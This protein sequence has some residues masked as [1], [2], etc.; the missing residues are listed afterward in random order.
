MRGL[1][2]LF[3][4]LAALAASC[5]DRGKPEPAAFS[6]LPEAPSAGDAVTIRYRPD[7]SGSPLARAASIELRY[8]LVS[9]AGDVRSEE[10]PMTSTGGAWSASFVPSE[11]MPEGP[12][13]LV[14]AF[15]NAD[16]RDAYDNNR[17][18]P[19]VVM[20]RED[21]RVAEGANLQLSRI[22]GGELRLEG[23]VEMSVDRDLARDLVRQELAIWP[24][25]RRAAAASWSLALRELREDPVRLDS[26][27]TAIRAVVDDYFRVSSSWA[28]LPPDAVPMLEMYDR[29]GAEGRHD[30]LSAALLSRF[31]ADSATAEYGVQALVD[32]RDL[33]G[34][35]SRLRD[36]LDEHPES[37]ASKLGRGMLLSLYMYRLGTPERAAE[38]VRTDRPID[39]QYLVGYAEWLAAQ[40]GRLGEAE[41]VFRRCWEEDRAAEWTSSGSASRSEW[42][43]FQR[44][45]LSRTGLGLAGVLKESGRGEEAASLLAELALA[46]GPGAEADPEVLVALAGAEEDLG[47]PADAVRTFERLAERWMPTAEALAGWRRAYEAAGSGS[48]FDAYSEGYRERRMARL[49]ERLAD[50]ALDRPAPDISF[51]DPTGAKSSLSDYRGKVVLIDFWATWCGPCRR[52]LPQ[53]DEIYAKRGEIGDFEILPI[54]VWERNAGEERRTAVAASWKELGLSM[55]YFL[56][57][58]APAGTGSPATDLFHVSGIP[59]S[60]VIGRDGKI[61]FKTVGYEGDSAIEEMRA[62]IAIALGRPPAA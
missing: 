48:D 7:L 6:V 3:A 30:S 19:W 21:G 18:D 60:F 49:I 38:V 23:P 45:R 24:E 27:R 59:T 36:F 12:V 1:T 26:L 42:M 16:D 13:L 33:E 61:L 50:R 62:K 46:E 11:R 14:A 28:A 43:E 47:R 22:R 34:S 4:A 44:W 32:R 51:E 25:N 55:P 15:A 2:V 37:P 8:S 40:P 58:D 31:P 17:D 57:P 10:V 41:T 9:A 54:N 56:D 39:T 35:A 20:F 29:I 53:L 5:A 52:S